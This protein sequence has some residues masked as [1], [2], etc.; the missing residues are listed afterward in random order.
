MCTQV[1]RCTAILKLNASVDY[2]WSPHTDLKSCLILKWSSK[3]SLRI[4]NVNACMTFWVSGSPFLDGLSPGDGRSLPELTGRRLYKPK[5]EG[6][7]IPPN[8]GVWQSPAKLALRVCIVSRTGS[9]WTVRPARATHRAGSGVQGHRSLHS[10]R[11]SWR[12]P[13]SGS[14]QC[15]R[16]ITHCSPRPTPLLLRNFQV[17]MARGHRLFLKPY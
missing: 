11:V 3:G 5:A 7:A 12:A 16:S 2:P 9:I 8:P 1:E 6:V 13:V 10:I 14:Q 17:K 4:V 15:C